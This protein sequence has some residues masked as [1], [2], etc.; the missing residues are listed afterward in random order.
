MALVLFTKIASLFTIALGTYFL[1]K[2]HILRSEDSHTLSLVMLYLVCP[3]TIVSAF[4]IEST[5]EI[6]TG[7]LLALGAALMIHVILLV[8]NALIRKPLHLTPIEQSSFLY[9]NAGN[10]II[11]IV[12][13]LLGSEWVIYTCAYICVQIILLWTHCKQLV[14]G[15]SRPNIKKI[16]TNV[17]ILSILAGIIIFVLNIQL[18]A[19]LQDAIDATAS[20][21][22]PIGMA[23]VG[24]MLAGMDFKSLFAKKRVWL[25]AFLRLIVAPLLFIFFLRLTGFGTG[26]QS[27][28]TILLISLLAC[29]SAASTTVMQMELIYGTDAQYAC[30]INVIT[31]ILCILTMPL[32][33]TIYEL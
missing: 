18:P 26:I 12:S 21:I 22:G 10:I 3:C 29:S 16:L 25:I 13:S 31:T 20:M 33:V 14:S 6:R 28:E 7:L 30:A 1:A 4:Q 5:S 8:F 23:I 27:S 17:N 32:I 9:S 2:F 19:F 15:E 11:P 24:L